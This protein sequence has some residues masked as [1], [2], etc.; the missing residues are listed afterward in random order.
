VAGLETALRSCRD[1]EP[2]VRRRLEPWAATA[3]EGGVAGFGDLV[4]VG[5]GFGNL[6]R[7]ER[8]RELRSVMT[9]DGNSTL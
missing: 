9:P 3:G 8:K 7:G 4:I 6:G 5:E 1:D 2:G